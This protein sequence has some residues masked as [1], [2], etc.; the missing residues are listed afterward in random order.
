MWQLM[1]KEIGGSKVKASELNLLGF[2]VN[3][4]VKGRKEGVGALRKR[5]RNKRRGHSASEQEVKSQIKWGLS[6]ILKNC[7]SEWASKIEEKNRE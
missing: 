4:S 3:K 1:K 5:Q 2:D 7:V 6:A